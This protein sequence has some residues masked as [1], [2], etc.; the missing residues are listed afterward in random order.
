[1]QARRS[2]LPVG[3]LLAAVAVSQSS[4]GGSDGPSHLGPIRAPGFEVVDPQGS[5]A[6]ASPVAGP[7]TNP[8]NGHDYY[9]LEAST[10]TA[11]EAA[12]V[13]LGGHLV[14]INDAAEDDWIYSTELGSA[15]H[16][17]IGFTDAAQE[18]NWVWI[19]G[20]PVTYTKW[21]PGSPLNVGGIEHY[22]EWDH[23]GWNDVPNDGWG[24]PHQGIVEVIP[25]A[26]GDGVPDSKDNCPAHPNQDQDDC[27]GDGIGDVCAIADGTSTDCDDD[28]L[29]D[30]C[31]PDID[32]DDVLNGDDV[33][34]FTPPTEYVEPD[35]S[36]LGDLDGDCDVDLDDF[37]LFLT[38][39]T[40]AGCS[41]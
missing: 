11:A 12:A 34:D 21:L 16:R 28:G 31:D 40:G 23:N 9:L 1:M 17:W 10:W 39:F 8:A 33:C 37:A 26:D 7:I 22:G 38:R 25:D 30:E 2:I 4:G 36:L 19:S 13:S 18:G 27:D 15:A 41:H 5:P 29:I 20:A 3:I 6:S 35:G 32:D 14:T 24:V